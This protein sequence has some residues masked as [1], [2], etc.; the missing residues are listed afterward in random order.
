MS[1][2]KCQC[3]QLSQFAHI[4]LQRIPTRPTPRVQSAISSD[5][6][7]R[8]GT[9]APRAQR[10]FRCFAL[11]CRFLNFWDAL[12][13]SKACIFCQSVGPAR[14]LKA[15]GGAMH[16]EAAVSRPH[17][18]TPVL[19]S[20]SPPSAPPHKAERL[21]VRGCLRVLLLHFVAL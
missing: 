17:Q 13:F 4:S 8:S 20:Q 7:W 11:R 1:R 2:G 5:P 16:A 15:F 18:L 12:Q 3:S 19:T 10:H 21:G 14:H 6:G 9:I